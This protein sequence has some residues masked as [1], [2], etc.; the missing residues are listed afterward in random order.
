MQHATDDGMVSIQ[1]DC[2]RTRAA[3]VIRAF[4]VLGRG[5]LA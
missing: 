1:R 4:E 2:Y 5:D 3:R